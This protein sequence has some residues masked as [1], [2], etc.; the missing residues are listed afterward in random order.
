[1]ILF[2]LIFYYLAL[3]V[4]FLFNICN[5]MIWYEPITRHVV[6]WNKMHWT[7]SFTDACKKKQVK[8]ALGVSILTLSDEW[9]MKFTWEKRIRPKRIRKNT[10]KNQNST[11]ITYIHAK[12]IEK[13]VTHIKN[14]YWLKTNEKRSTH[15][16]QINNNC[17]VI[18]NG[19]KSFLIKT[20]HHKNGEKV[21]E[22]FK[23]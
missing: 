10:M 2:Y 23:M 12:I 14:T 6:K 4:F 3:F 1:M 18:Y 20:N 15:D 13:K 21:Q 9:R 7:W 8:N 17:V 5:T 11:F 22:R 19:T 16:V